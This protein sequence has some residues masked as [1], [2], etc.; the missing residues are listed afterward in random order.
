M[1]FSNFFNL[2][3]H[4]INI[5]VIE[6]PPKMCKTRSSQMLFNKLVIPAGYFDDILLIEAH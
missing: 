1:L 2:A 3:H 4:F 6:I 5:I